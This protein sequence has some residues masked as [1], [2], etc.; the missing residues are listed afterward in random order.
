MN[1]DVGGAESGEPSSAAAE[2]SRARDASRAATLAAVVASLLFV[3]GWLTYQ[4]Q[5]Y[6]PPTGDGSAA[7]IVGVVAVVPG[8]LMG[9]TALWVAA[10]D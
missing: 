1:R 6:G 5:V 9:A 3:P 7:A 4:F 10:H 2:R 8:F